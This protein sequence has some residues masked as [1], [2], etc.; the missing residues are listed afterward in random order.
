LP[1]GKM[2]EP[3]KGQGITDERLHT[4]MLNVGKVT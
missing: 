4:E 2:G 1:L 3:G